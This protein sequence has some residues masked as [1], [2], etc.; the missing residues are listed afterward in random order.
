MNKR[1]WIMTLG[2]C[3]ACLSP[4]AQAAFA[5][6]LD[7]AALPS[8]LA[9]QGLF[10]GLAQAGQRLVAVGQRGH[11]LYSD[12]QGEHWQQ[13]AV[14]V[15][16]DLTAVC[17]PTAMDGW[18]VGHD[19]VILVSHDGGKN[20]TRQLDGHAIGAL[21]QRWYQDHAPAGLS[22]DVLTKL[23]SDADRFASEGPDKPFLDV[24]F[25]D[26]RHGFVVGAFNLILHTD[27]GGATWV[28]WLDRSA[29]PQQ[30]HLYAIRPVGADLYVVGE[31]GLVMKLA[32]AAERFE[33]LTLPYKGTLFGVTGEQGA[34]IVYGLRGHAF[35]SVDAGAHWSPVDTGVQVSLTSAVVANHLL[36]ISSQAGQLLS[37]TDGGV[38]FQTLTLD[39]RFPASALLRLSDNSILFAGPRGLHRVKAMHQMEG[40]P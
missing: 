14:P 38:S 24:W 25:S 18:A 11:I 6:P 10:N 29:N 12:D 5:D 4:L 21:L 20:W 28:P 30:F 32:A 33:A 19:G 1:L 9:Q 26:A 13:A 35:R 7:T 3:L 36:L 37:S 23:R 31:Q 8:A 27:D 40:K 16:S 17:F 34:V 39:Q 15:S 22:A 2:F